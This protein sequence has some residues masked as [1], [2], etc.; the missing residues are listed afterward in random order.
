MKMVDHFTEMTAG[1][2]GEAPEITQGIHELATRATQFLLS[3]VPVTQAHGPLESPNE[4]SKSEIAEFQRYYEIVDDP[5]II[6]DR[7]SIW[8]F[9][10][11]II[12]F[13]HRFI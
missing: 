4:P 7:F 12:P 9:T 13:F 8:V 10:V 3:K 1:I 11:S 6:F 2:S 5:L